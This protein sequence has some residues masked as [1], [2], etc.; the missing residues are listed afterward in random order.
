MSKRV[1][2]TKKVSLSVH[3]DDLRMLKERA[4]RVHGG[5]VSA[6]FAELILRVRREEALRKALEWYGKPIPLSEEDR[7][8]IDLEIFGKPATA[9]RTTGD[10]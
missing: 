2:V 1:G 9:R 5:N 3:R 4:K 8:R 10:R 6:V 7:A